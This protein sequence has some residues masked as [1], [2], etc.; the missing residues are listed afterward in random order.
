MLVTRG[1]TAHLLRGMQDQ[2]CLTKTLPS[3]KN[4]CKSIR[5]EK[6]DKDATQLPHYSIPQKTNI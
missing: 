1:A 2:C 6:S 4:L 3:Q 5:D